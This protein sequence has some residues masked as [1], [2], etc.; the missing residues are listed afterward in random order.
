MN[1]REALTEQIAKR[2]TTVSSTEEKA[3]EVG[4]SQ[5]EQGAGTETL[6]RQ[7]VA[8]EVSMGV[9]GQAMDKGTS[10]ALKE[11][12]GLKLSFPALVVDRALSSLDE[13]L[14]FGSGGERQEKAG[15]KVRRMETAAGR[16]RCWWREE[17]Y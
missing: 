5:F 12:S 7:E 6:G 9:W 17:D 13:L 3:G 16:G 4:L 8:E 14:S 15:V 11:M 1:S 2:A 10:M